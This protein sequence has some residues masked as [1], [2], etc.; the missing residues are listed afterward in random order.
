MIV[1]FILFLV[2][3]LSLGILALTIISF[4]VLLA[5]IVV[6]IKFGIDL[7]K[8]N[9]PYFQQIR[10]F[11]DKDFEKKRNYKEESYQSFINK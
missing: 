9:K 4:V 1:L 2:L 10:E 8:I 3:G 5:G 6:T 7:K 11:S